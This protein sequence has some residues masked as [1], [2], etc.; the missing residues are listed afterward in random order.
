MLFKS[1]QS[2]TSSIQRTSSICI[3]M[4]RQ[5]S[6]RGRPRVSFWCRGDDHGRPSVDCA[7]I[8]TDSCVFM[9]FGAGFLI[10]LRIDF[11]GKT[12]NFKIVKLLN[13]LPDE[14]K[15]LFLLDRVLT[16]GEQL[17]RDEKKKMENGFS[18]KGMKRPRFM[19]VALVNI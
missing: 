7:L 12:L 10:L 2:R 9:I 6:P 5:P 17:T 14:L 19:I 18:P 15:Q 3:T 13:S 1:I 16:P 11:I 4:A 8:G